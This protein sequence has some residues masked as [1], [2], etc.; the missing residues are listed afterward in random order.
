[1]YQTARK[2]IGENFLQ[3]AYVLST[4]V[5]KLS[6]GKN[7]TFQSILELLKPLLYSPE[8]KEGVVVASA[9]LLNQGSFGYMIFGKT[10]E[11]A[12]S[13]EEKMKSLLEI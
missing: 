5:M 2:L 11:K 4:N 12:L 8:T 10:K 13:I 9:N 1:M 6:E 3:D 7:F